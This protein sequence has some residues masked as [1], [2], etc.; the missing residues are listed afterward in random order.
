MPPNSYARKS[1]TS[2]SGSIW[3]TCSPWALWQF[4]RLTIKQSML[5]T[6]MGITTASIGRSRLG[7]SSIGCVPCVDEL[8]NIHIQPCGREL[9]CPWSRHQHS[10]EKGQGLGAESHQ[11]VCLHSGHVDQGRDREGYYQESTQLSPPQC[12]LWQVNWQCFE[13]VIVEGQAEGEPH[14]SP[15]KELFTSEEDRDS[16]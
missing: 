6:G 10:E 15:P 7:M 1:A 12:H 13:D 5:L 4:C 3:Y 9:A 2:I 14:S 11:E 8:K 16:W